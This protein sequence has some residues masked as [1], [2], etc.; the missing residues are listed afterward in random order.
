M[1]FS[2]VEILGFLAVY[3][4]MCFGLGVIFMQYRRMKTLLKDEARLLGKLA[5]TER[6]FSARTESLEQEYQDKTKELE[7]EY[8]QRLADAILD[9]TKN[10]E[11]NEHNAETPRLGT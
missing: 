4:L 10:V 3:G 1:R 2:G 11:D 6:E 8:V 9:M 5:E 7:K